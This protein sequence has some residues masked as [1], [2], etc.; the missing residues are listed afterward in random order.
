MDK[1]SK[2]ILIAFGLAI[3][4]LVVFEISRPKPLDWS[5]NYTA[6]A[7]SPLGSFVTFQEMEDF[8]DAPLKRITKDPFEF[9]QDSLYGSGELY[10]FV[11]S[12]LDIDENQLDKLEDFATAG[13]TVFLSANYFG[14]A[15]YERFSISAMTDY[16]VREPEV[17]VQLYNPNLAL[18]SLAQFKRSVYAS[19]FTEVDT[20]NTTALGFMNYTSS[21]LFEDETKTDLLNY[22][23]IPVGDGWFYF[24]TL[25]H[26]FS[27]YYMLNGNATYSARVL[28]YLNPQQVYWDEYLK[29][30]RIIVRSPMRF[31]LN[32]KG[33]KWGYY[34]SI[35]GLLLFVLIRAKREQRMIPLVE[36]LRNDTKDFTATIG[37][38][39][40][41][42]KN[43][44]NIIAKRI[45]YFLERVR[46]EYLL[47]TEHL[48]ET[49]V[50]R[51][52]S[53]SGNTKEDSGDLVRL[54][55]SLRGKTLHTENDLIELNKALEKFSN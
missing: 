50:E 43:Y 53:K 49:F 5:S 15:V 55:N 29:D 20:I 36:P 24:H 42:Y 26:A 34:L 54:I 39:H 30:G 32:Q 46:S 40:F 41:Q 21:A 2:R 22:I 48:D 18:D 51:L 7:K 44:S 33:L 14:S 12:G 27:N 10:F 37:N 38:L 3:L 52:A 11:N 25:P 16:S 45:T 19:E 17:S 13:N 8:F 35:L 28:S 1:R 6:T 31:V 9:L 23:R 4:L 47:N